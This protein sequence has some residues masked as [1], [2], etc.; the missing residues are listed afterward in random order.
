MI[1]A[2]HLLP[3]VPNMS[4]NYCIVPELSHNLGHTIVN[5]VGWG[6]GWGGGGGA[7]GGGAGGGGAGGREDRSKKKVVTRQRKSNKVLVIVG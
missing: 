6:W 7:G 2:N 3:M 1:P 5:W 4:G